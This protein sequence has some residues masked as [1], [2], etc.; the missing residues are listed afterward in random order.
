[1]YK[2]NKPASAEMNRKSASDSETR[3]TLE[4]TLKAIEILNATMN[5][6]RNQDNAMDMEMQALELQMKDAQNKLLRLAGNIKTTKESVAHLESVVGSLRAALSP[7]RK[8][9]TE[10]LL[11]IFLDFTQHYSRVL[12]SASTRWQSP[13]MLGREPIILA[14]VCSTWGSI[15]M[16]NPSVWTP[17]AIR[18]SKMV[19][20]PSRRDSERIAHWIKS[21]PP[22][23]QILWLIN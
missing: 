5:D 11:R 1:L 15:V 2:R 6:Y 13:A 12:E 10:I 20:A 16:S 8:L 4:S 23:R 7:V 21:C 9:P 19:P 14:G 22:S 3:S 17:L 18:I